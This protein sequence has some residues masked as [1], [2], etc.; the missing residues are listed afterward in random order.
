MD[1]GVSGWT[2]GACSVGCGG[3]TQSQTRSITTAPKG[4]GLACPALTASQA[5]NAGVRI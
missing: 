2:L 5:C 1:C 3:G 4:T